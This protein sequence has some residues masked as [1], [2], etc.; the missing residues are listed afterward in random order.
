MGRSPVARARHHFIDPW[1]GFFWASHISNSL[2]LHDGKDNMITV[3][4]EIASSSPVNLSQTFSAAKLDF[5]A[6]HESLRN[7]DLENEQPIWK[8]LFAAVYT[9]IAW[10]FQSPV[11]E[12]T[13]TKDG[14]DEAR[15]EPAVLSGTTV[16][17]NS[18]L[19]RRHGRE[20]SSAVV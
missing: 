15:E 1:Q 4:G 9:P 13:R 5:N 3:V 6:A 17:D 20:S 14:S 8:D 7:R 11:T 12:N 16:V 2:G 18:G 19:M 10:I